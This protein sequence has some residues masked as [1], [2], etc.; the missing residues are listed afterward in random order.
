MPARA[1]S[2]D[3][4]RPYAI[5]VTIDDGSRRRLDLESE[6]SGDVFEPLRDPDLF[7]Q[8]RID[9]EWGTIAWPTGADLSPEF[10]YEASEELASEKSPAVN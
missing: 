7:A 2:L 6:L 10:L 1:V 9:P 4:I 5:E 3:V 8:A